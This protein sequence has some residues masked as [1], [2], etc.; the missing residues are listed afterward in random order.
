M[1]EVKEEAQLD[2]QE[3]HFLGGNIVDTVRPS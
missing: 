1:R 3:L 2:V